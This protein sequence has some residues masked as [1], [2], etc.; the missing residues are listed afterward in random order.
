MSEAGT[1]EVVFYTTCY[2]PSNGDY[3]VYSAPVTITA[4]EGVAVAQW[5]ISLRDDICPN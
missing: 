4:T 5:N 3:R 1:A 2:T